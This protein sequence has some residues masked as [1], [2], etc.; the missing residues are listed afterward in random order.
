MEKTEKKAPEK[1]KGA[2]AKVQEAMEVPSAQPYASGGVTAPVAKQA[3]VEVSQEDP[4]YN[5]MMDFATESVQDAWQGVKDAAN[6][7]GDAIAKGAGWVWEQAK[8]PEFWYGAA[9][10]LA[11][12]LEGDVAA[13]AQVGADT[14]KQ[15]REDE[16]E[17]LKKQ[18]KEA[19]GR[20]FQLKYVL[21]P[22]S[23]NDILVN[24]E[25]KGGN[26][27]RLDDLE[28]KDPITHATKKL[29]IEQTSDLKLDAKIKEAEEMGYAT[30]DLRKGELEA[31]REVRTNLYKNLRTSEKALSGAMSSLKGFFTGNPAEK[32]IAVT[33]LAKIING[34]RVSDYDVISLMRP[35]F[36]GTEKGREYLD[37]VAKGQTPQLDKAIERNIQAIITNTQNQIGREY[38]RSYKSLSEIMPE[39]KARLHL[40]APTY[41]TKVRLKTPKGVK[42][43][44]RE[45][46]RKFV[47]YIE[48]GRMEIL[49]YE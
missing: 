48:D 3:G 29:G 14:L 28:K 17:L 10:L 43:I 1:K 40:G 27:Y 31:V 24:Y 15:A 8:T 11:G 42:L 13:G 9:P 20:T 41:T 12:I 16:M 46:L 39:S 32:R 35:A 4:E 44:P 23:G 34:G 36:G 30:K 26:V 45:D 37:L 7:A 6:D 33:N 49:K 38:Y 22:T 18:K 5:K 2:W 19:E 25:P 21:D 47:P